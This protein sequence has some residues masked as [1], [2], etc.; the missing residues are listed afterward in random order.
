MVIFPCIINCCAW[1][2]AAP[3]FLLSCSHRAQGALPRLSNL[4]FTVSLK[5]D[6]LISGTKMETKARGSEVTCQRSQGNQVVEL[7]FEHKS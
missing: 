3:S 1:F 4:I 2:R 5:E 7:G 6:C